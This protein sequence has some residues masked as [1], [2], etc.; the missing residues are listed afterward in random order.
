[1]EDYDGSFENMCNDLDRLQ[2]KINRL[3]PDVESMEKAIPP[4]QRGKVSEYGKVKEEYV[5]ARADFEKIYDTYPKLRFDAKIEQY[6][7]EE[8]KGHLSV[9]GGS[10]F[11]E[12]T[13]VFGSSI[14]SSS[15]VP[16]VIPGQKLQISIKDLE[17]I[18]DGGIPKYVFAVDKLFPSDEDLDRFK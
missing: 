9:K 15:G 13:A 16:F 17:K 11:G 1:M 12:T 3:K 14:L 7:Y 2:K 18:D 10:V 8:G 4:D 5:E 6:D